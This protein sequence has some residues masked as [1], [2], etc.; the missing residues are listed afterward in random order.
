MAVDAPDEVRLDFSHL[1]D[2]QLVLI[3]QLVRQLQMN[4]TVAPSDLTKPTGKCNLLPAVR[5]LLTRT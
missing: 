4:N 5:I 1:L 2:R 3:E